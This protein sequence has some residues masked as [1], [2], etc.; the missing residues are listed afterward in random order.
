MFI[1]LIQGALLLMT[2]MVI[3]LSTLVDSKKVCRL[4]RKPKSLDVPSPVDA[5]FASFKTTEA[6]LIID[7]KDDL[8]TA[9]PLICALTPKPAGKMCRLRPRKLK[10]KKNKKKK[11]RLPFCPEEEDQMES[12]TTKS[13][14]RRMAKIS[15]GNFIHKHINI[16]LINLNE[17]IYSFHAQLFTFRLRRRMQAEAKGS[18]EVES[19]KETQCFWRRCRTT[20]S[21][22]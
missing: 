2:L 10:K 20:P 11:L 19:S 5:L 16:I 3:D 8:L 13:R 21:F 22:S 9:S 1:H 6:P 12:A 7:A 14:V 4:R 15:K 17:I 18:K